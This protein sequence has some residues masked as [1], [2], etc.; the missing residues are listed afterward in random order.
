MRKGVGD[1]GKPNDLDEEPL[2]HSDFG[3]A[4]L[5]RITCGTIEAKYGTRPI[6]AAENSRVPPGRPVRRF[7]IRYVVVGAAMLGYLTL[8]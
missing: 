4:R 8:E 3:I 1:G 5:H 6:A 2:G 7:H